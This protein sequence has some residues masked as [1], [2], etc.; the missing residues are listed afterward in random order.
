MEKVSWALIFW[1][2]DNKTSI[3]QLS[4][5]QEAIPKQVLRVGWKGN[6]P[7]T[8]EKDELNFYGAAILKISSK[9]K[10]SENKYIISNFV[11]DCDYLCDWWFS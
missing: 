7:W 2:E 3:M 5:I 11:S 8:D 9:Y 10:H 6:L 1:S 4:I